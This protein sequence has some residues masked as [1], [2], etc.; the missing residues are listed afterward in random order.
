MFI[1]VEEEKLKWN[2]GVFKSA[3]VAFDAESKEYRGAKGVAV[4]AALL[5]WLNTPK[6]VRRQYLDIVKIAEGRGLD[7]TVLEAAKP[8]IDASAGAGGLTGADSKAVL[9]HSDRRTTET[10]KRC[11]NRK[12]SGTDD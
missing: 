12:R 3:A 8:L 1:L 2:L 4:T 5:L 7:G 9:G 11:R 6:K 10:K